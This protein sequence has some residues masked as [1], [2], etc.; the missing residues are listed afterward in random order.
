[1]LARAHLG[2]AAHDRSPAIF[3]SS[4]PSSAFAQRRRLLHRGQ[5]LDE[6]RE[7]AMPTPVIGKFSS[8]RSVCTP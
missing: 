5:R 8:A 1:M 7:F 6:R 3:E 2:A 4:S